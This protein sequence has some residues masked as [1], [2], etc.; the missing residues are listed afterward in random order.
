MFPS[1]LADIHLTLPRNGMHKANT[2]SFTSQRVSSNQFTIW[3]KRIF[4]SSIASFSKCTLTNT[5]CCS[6]EGKTI[7]KL[8]ESCCNSSIQS[9]ISLSDNKRAVEVPRRLLSFFFFLH[10]W[11]EKEE[12]DDIHIM[13]R[14]NRVSFIQNNWL[15]LIWCLKG[16]VNNFFFMF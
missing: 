16:D 1:S 8:V 5:T 4:W 3:V 7:Y 10:N 11:K 13:C 9:C 2:T 6:N 15:I 14:V 12:K